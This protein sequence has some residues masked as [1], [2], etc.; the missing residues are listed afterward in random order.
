MVQV[1]VPVQDEAIGSA[2]SGLDEKLSAWVIAVT[3][4]Q[5]ALVGLSQ[6]GAKDGPKT[7]GSPKRQGGDQAAGDMQAPSPMEALQLMAEAPPP[8]APP[9]VQPESAAP[10]PREE[11]APSIEPVA[12][13]PPP[14]QPPA[15]TSA[16]TRNAIDPD[17]EVVLS[18]LDEKTVRALRVLRRLSPVKKSMRVLL[19]EYQAGQGAQP[20]VAPAKKSWWK[21]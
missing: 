8:E 18:Q 10:P 3:Q 12:V 20:D 2:L 17:D 6:R 9:D 7:P 15:Q 21:R 16:E 5:D 4:A 1:T 11:P 13:K 14:V 19:A